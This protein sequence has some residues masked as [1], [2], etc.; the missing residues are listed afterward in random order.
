[1]ERMERMCGLD[2]LQASSDAMD[3]RRQHTSAGDIPS[4]NRETG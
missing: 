3:M 2:K 4:T 1:M